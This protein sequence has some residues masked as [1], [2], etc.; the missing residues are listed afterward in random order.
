MLNL[1]KQICRVICIYVRLKRFFFFLLAGVQ[2]ALWTKQGP[3]ECRIDDIVPMAWHVGAGLAYWFTV[4]PMVFMYARIY[5]IIMSSRRRLSVPDGGL[6]ANQRK[7]SYKT[8]KMLFIT[9]GVFVLCWTPEVIFVHLLLEKKV[10]M[11]VVYASYVLSYSNS[12]MNFFIY[13]A[14]SP[15]YKMAF[16]MMCCFYCKK[17]ITITHSNSSNEKE[18]TS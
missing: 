2:S 18:M 9:L 7:T 14:N 4:V 17:K 1:L 6:R 10:S 15:K 13:A 11:L 12:A 3:L 8:T 16:K 5:Y